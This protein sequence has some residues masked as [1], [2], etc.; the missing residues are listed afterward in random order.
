MASPVSLRLAPLRPVQLHF[1]L[2]RARIILDDPA[3]AHELHKGGL[4]NGGRKAAH[5]D[6]RVP[7]LVHLEPALLATGRLLLAFALFGFTL[8]ELKKLENKKNLNF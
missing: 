2:A 5:I 8:L 1:G 3:F 4:I 7:L 6:A